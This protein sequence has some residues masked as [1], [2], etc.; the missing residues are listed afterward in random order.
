MATTVADIGRDIPG[1]VREVRDIGR[2]IPGTAGLPA[3]ALPLQRFQVRAIVRA[4]APEIV[5]PLQTFQVE[6]IARMSPVAVRDRAG[7]RR[8][9]CRLVRGTVRTLPRIHDPARTRPAVI[10]APK[11]PTP[12]LRRPHVRMRFQDP[13]EGVRRVHVGTRVLEPKVA[14]EVASWCET[15]YQTQ[16]GAIAPGSF[17]VGCDED[18]GVV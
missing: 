6:G 15:R 13:Q 11:P 4:I 1:I 2:D 10:N 7:G 16:S 3:I 14:R 5:L 17:V 18:E 8:L 12:V 9:L